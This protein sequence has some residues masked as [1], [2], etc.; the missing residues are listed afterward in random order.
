MIDQSGASFVCGLIVGFIFGVTVLR[1]MMDIN[2][3]LINKKEEE[4]SANWWKNG[5]NPFDDQP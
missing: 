3:S 1:N 2:I 4:D 5:Q